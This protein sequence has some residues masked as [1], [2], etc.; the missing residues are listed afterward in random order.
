MTDGSERR[1]RKT[2]LTNEYVNEINAVFAK[3]CEIMEDDYK[4]KIV[5][6]DEWCSN[7]IQEINDHATKQKYLLDNVYNNEKCL[8]KKQLEENLEVTDNYYNAQQESLFNELRKACQKLKYKL[9]ELRYSKSEVDFLNVVERT[10]ETDKDALKSARNRRRHRRNDDK[11][12]ENNASSETRSSD[13]TLNSEHITDSQQA[14]STSEPN[15]SSKDDS[16]NKC[17][18]CYMMFPSSFTRINRLE[19]ANAHME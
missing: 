1:C 4:S 12:T 10:E 18:L 8:L 5:Q 19:H 13:S 2:R 3:H 14:N 17:P 16:D 6:I 15:D 11:R 9:S 7:F